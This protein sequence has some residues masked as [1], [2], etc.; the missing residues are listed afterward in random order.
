MKT[1]MI[2]AAGK[3]ERLKPLTEKLPKAMCIVNNRP[4]IEHHVEN[5][6]KANFTKIIINHAHLGGQIRRYLG[7]GKKWAI[8][9]VYTPEPPGGL[10]TGGGIFNALPCLGDEPFITVNADVFTDFN[11][12]TLKLT[13]GEMTK[14]IL[15]DNPQYKK[16]GDFDLAQNNLLSNI[17]KR[18]TFAGIA[19]YHPKAF[20]N[21]RIGRYSVVNLLHQLITANQATGELYKGLWMDI[22]T[23]ERLQLA[24]TLNQGL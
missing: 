17:T 22:G 21:Y 12:N 9:I 24:N 18:Y 14:L 23:V 4:L 13:N 5:L 2:L 10:E 1:A 20:K 19:C 3:G 7:N 16:Q 8:E 15:V 11:F 6:A